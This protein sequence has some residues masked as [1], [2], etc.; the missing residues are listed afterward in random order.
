MSGGSEIIMARLKEKY[1]TEALPKLKEEFGIKNDLAAPRIKKVVLNVG[2]GEAKDNA[3]VLEK[4][5][6]NLQA[7]SGQRPVV[8]KAKKSIAG[9]KLGKG[10]PIGMMVTLRDDRMYEFLDKFMNIVLP[11]VRDFRGVS[12]TSFDKQGNFTIGLKE[13]A[14]FPEVVFQSGQSAMRAKGLEIS[15]VTGAKNKEQGKRLLDL[16]GM[17]FKKESN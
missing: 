9:F 1:Q 4:V 17:P 10:Q 8:V 3:Q 15:I 11:K 6:E 14:I 2:V 16:L 13:Q 5:K 12:D 7:L